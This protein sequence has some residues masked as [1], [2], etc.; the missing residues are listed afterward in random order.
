MSFLS[1]ILNVIKFLKKIWNITDNNVLAYESYLLLKK[2]LPLACQNGNTKYFLNQKTNQWE[3]H[4]SVEDLKVIRDVGFNAEYALKSVFVGSGLSK[5]PFK[6]LFHFFYFMSLYFTLANI[7]PLYMA[8]GYSGFGF[9]FELI[10]PG[11]VSGAYQ[12]RCRNILTKHN[13]PESIDN[14]EDLILYSSSI[15]FLGFV[16]IT[17]GDLEVADKMLEKYFY[18]LEEVGQNKSEQVRYDWYIYSH[19]V[20]CVLGKW[21][22]FYQCIEY[23]IQRMIVLDK[24]SEAMAEA[25][26]GLINLK[27]LRGEIDEAKIIETE[28]NP[29]LLYENQVFKY[30]LFSEFF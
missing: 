20:L 29:S 22:T 14:N 4:L 30:Y 7:N 13:Y 8:K 16:A 2:Y 19:M 23:D 21:G 1:G 5:V 12:E 10:F 6:W 27:L 24:F 17:Q 15:Q 9:L 11:N 28:H 3:F 25:Q 26:C 18:I